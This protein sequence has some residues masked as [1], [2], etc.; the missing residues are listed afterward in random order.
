[1]KI[2]KP[3]T[4]DINLLFANRTWN[5]QAKFLCKKLNG[6]L[7][8]HWPGESGWANSCFCTTDQRKAFIIAIDSILNKKLPNGIE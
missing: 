5:Q 4:I 2:V 1:M 8:Y 3:E 6:I 7:E